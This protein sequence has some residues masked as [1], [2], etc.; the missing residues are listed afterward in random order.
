MSRELTKKQFDIL[1]LLI[2]GKSPLSQ[3]QIEEKIGRSLGTVN[4]VM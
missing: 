1:A 2:E 4:R 3:R